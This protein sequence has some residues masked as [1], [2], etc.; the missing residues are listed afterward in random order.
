MSWIVAT[1]YSEHFIY[2]SHFVLAAGPI[3]Y[4]LALYQL[5]ILDI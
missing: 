3:S 4:L 5:F 1:Q 2:F